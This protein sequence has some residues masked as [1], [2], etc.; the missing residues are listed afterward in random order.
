MLGCLSLLRL[1]GLS[2]QIFWNQCTANSSVKR[3]SNASLPLH[4]DS[5]WHR[6]DLASWRCFWPLEGNRRWDSEQHQG[7]E[8]LAR[9]A[10]ND[11]LFWPSTILSMLY[12]LDIIWR[13]SFWYAK[14][15]RKT[16]PSKPKMFHSHIMIFVW[17]SISSNL[18]SFISVH[19]VTPWKKLKNRSPSHSLKVN[20]HRRSSV[21]GR[22]ESLS[23]SGP[24]RD[25]AKTKPGVKRV[26]PS[27]KL[28]NH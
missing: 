3:V 12:I 22:P 14:A 15:S 13:K 23:I 7:F 27:W 21:H 26:K 6:L 25:F 17:I 24:K 1:L 5:R 2:K 11:L 8:P 9:N 10:S 19:Q 4:R 28:K 18:S 20:E 16:K